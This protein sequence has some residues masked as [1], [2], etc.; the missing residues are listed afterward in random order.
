[1]GGLLSRRKKPPGQKCK[2]QNPLP[3][4][5]AEN[6]LFIAEEQNNANVYA[7]NSPN[8]QPRSIRNQTLLDTPNFNARIEPVAKEGNQV[9]KTHYFLIEEP[10]YRRCNSSKER[11]NPIEMYANSSRLFNQFCEEPLLPFDMNM[12]ITH[13]HNSLQVR[14]GRSDTTD[15]LYN[16]QRAM[17]AQM[18]M[19]IP[20]ATYVESHGVLMGT[21]WNFEEAE[22]RL[23]MELVHRAIGANYKQCEALLIKHS[24]NLQCAMSS[25]YDHDP[26]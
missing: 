17:V 19:K 6:V 3:A 4:H 2:F 5:E 22:R 18:Q 24:W 21:N 23:K 12:H 20:Q 13:E 25:L 15:Y 10:K 11:C 1:M 16:Q 9:S 7:I 8:R 14:R 26:N